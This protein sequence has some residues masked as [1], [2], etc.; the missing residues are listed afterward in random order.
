MQRSGADHD[1]IGD[2]TEEGHDEAIV[3]VAVGNEL[4]RPR[5]RRDR[6]DAVDRRDEVGDQPR[7]THSERAAVALAQ[8]VGQVELGT[9]V[10]AG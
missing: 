2:S 7:P 9:I 5:N 1:R 8:I 6:D 4:T 3:I 10:S